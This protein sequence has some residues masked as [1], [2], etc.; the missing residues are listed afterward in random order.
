MRCD[1]E[2]EKRLILIIRLKSR[3]KEQRKGGKQRKTCLY[4]F[5]GN[6]YN[7]GMHA[8]LSSSAAQ[9]GSFSIGVSSSSTAASAHLSLCLDRPIII[10]VPFADE[11]RVYK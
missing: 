2:N 6:T 5:Q 9:I 10:A 8:P 11:M 1:K 7:E 4:F 3:Q